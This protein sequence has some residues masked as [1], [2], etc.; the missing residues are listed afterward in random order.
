MSAGIR[1]C[2]AF[3]APGAESL[4]D[5]RLPAGATVADAVA[6]SALIPRLGLDPAGIAFAVFGQRADPDTP[7]ADGD[8]VE[9]TRPLAAEPMQVRRQRARERPLPKAAPKRKARPPAA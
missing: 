5:L 7:L 1:V 6:Q 4:V 3:A 8:R 2:V 9:L